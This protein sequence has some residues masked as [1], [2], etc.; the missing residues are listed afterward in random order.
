MLCNVLFEAFSLSLDLL[1]RQLYLQEERFFIFV[2]IELELFLVDVDAR[3]V[4]INIV[5]VL[6]MAVFTLFQL[7]SKSVSELDNLVDYGNGF[8]PPDAKLC[9]IVDFRLE[10]F[11]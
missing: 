10:I 11:F 4:N 5:D 7:T 9:L 8:S 1:K 3:H 2:K 6:T